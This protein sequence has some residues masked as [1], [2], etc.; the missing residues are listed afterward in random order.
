M[1]GISGKLLYPRSE[2]F[3]APRSHK[4]MPREGLVFFD[5]F[6]LVMPD[7]GPA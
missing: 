6:E 1:K 3:P 5:F 2:F 7:W 4:I